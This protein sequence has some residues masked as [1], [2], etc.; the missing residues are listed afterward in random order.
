MYILILGQVD[1]KE[2]INILNK[3]WSERDN[4]FLEANDSIELVDDNCK[5][6]VDDNIYLS[7]I[8]SWRKKEVT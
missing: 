5:I 2:E 6:G 7:K 8:K 3:P 4:C 1:S